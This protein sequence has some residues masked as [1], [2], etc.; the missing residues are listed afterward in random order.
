M[1][2]RSPENI[3]SDNEDIFYDFD[4]SE[5]KG[6][7][8]VKRAFEVAAAGFHN[9]CLIGPPGAGKSMMAKR[10]NSILPPLS[11]DEAL[12]TTRIYSVAGKNSCKGL[13]TRRPFRAPHHTIS[14]VALIGVGANPIPGEIRLAHNAVLH[15]DE[16][17]EF[18]K[19]ALKV[20]LQPLTTSKQTI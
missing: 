20:L 10:L 15:L 16:F 18:S 11:I 5:V 19:Q 7:D 13:I 4:F 12:E 1:L 3:Y 9:I 14:S 2:F 17:T 8:D 6:Q